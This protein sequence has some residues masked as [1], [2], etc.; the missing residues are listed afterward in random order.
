MAGPALPLSSQQYL[1]WPEPI[2]VTRVFT[3][4]ASNVVTSVAGAGVYQRGNREGAP[5]GGVYTKW[6]IDVTL[7]MGDVPSTPKPADLVGWMG[8]TYTVQ[9]VDPYFWLQY[10]KLTCLNLILALDLQQ[11]G[12][13]TRPNNAKDSTGK[14]SPSA[15]TTIA[16]N[17]PCR[18]Q[19]TGGTATDIGQR[20]TMPLRYTTYVGG[21]F[22]PRAKDV[23][24]VA[25]QGYTVLS[26][27]MPQR[28]DELMTLALE[29]LDLPN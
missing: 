23:F 12:T 11:S 13:L 3:N 19:P 2:T 24:T 25:G 8:G 6:T 10:Y 22:T 16:A 20:R 1:S 7:G 21:Q 28:I 29:S 4:P 5:S 9:T 18:L 15:Y 26:F 27:A 14:L 17:V